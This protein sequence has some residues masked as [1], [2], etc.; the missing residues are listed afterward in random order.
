MTEENKN[1]HKIMTLEARIKHLEKEVI[2]YKYDQLT[3]L[4]TRI[5]FQPMFDNFIHDANTYQDKQFTLAII[6]INNLHNINEVE[7]HLV[8]DSII[9][10]VA[11]TVSHILHDS[12]V[13]RIGGDEFAVLSRTETAESITE[14]LA[15]DGEILSQITVGAVDSDEYDEYYSM[16][17]AADLLMQSKKVKEKRL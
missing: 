7:G 11:D 12:N 6:D 13:F 14:K 2:K 3:N 1:K 4:P 5:D 9:V 16:F 17:H 10:S 15:K 8:G